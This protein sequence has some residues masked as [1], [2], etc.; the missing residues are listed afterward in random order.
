ME[1]TL[2][3]LFLT[4]FVPDEIK[5]RT[6][7]FPHFVYIAV[8]VLAIYFAARY[9]RKIPQEKAEKII[10]VLALSLIVI[11]FYRFYMFRKYDYKYDFIDNLP[12]HLCIINQFVIPYAVFRK[13]RVLLNLSYC[14]GAPAAAI[15]ILTP[16]ELYK[17]YFYLSWYAI[18]FFLL[19]F[20]I[21]L[22][23]ILCINAKIFRPDYKLMPKACGVFLGFTA[24]V[25]G[26]NKLLNANFMFINIPE[27]GT[28]M[29]P[30]YKWLGNPG[31]I[32]PL[33]I[34]LFFVLFMMYLPWII[35]DKRAE[36]RV[37]EYA[38]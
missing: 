18:F 26:L 11:Y 12:F 8:I 2:F 4:R 27:P 20:L 28:L 24:F 13:N 23:P 36:R 32:A 5:F 7:S 9:I 1:Y 19:H 3:D 6:F 15:A 22:L 37:L 21:V 34:V 33:L 17:D 25:Y 16:S 35:I 10:K 14:I 31:F 29:E 30:F 38:E